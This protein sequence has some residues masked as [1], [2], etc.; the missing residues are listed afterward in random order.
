MAHATAA[1]IPFITIIPL[2]VS[3]RAF[4]AVVVDDGLTRGEIDGKDRENGSQ[5]D[6]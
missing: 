2:P 6:W 4:G 1:F 3:R 5:A